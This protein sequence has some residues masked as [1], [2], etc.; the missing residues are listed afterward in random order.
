MRGLSKNVFIS[1]VDVIV[2]S[3][4]LFIVLVSVSLMRLLPPQ[5]SPGEPIPAI[6]LCDLPLGLGMFKHSISLLNSR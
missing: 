1:Y 4:F 3:T 5:P 6:F 2:H